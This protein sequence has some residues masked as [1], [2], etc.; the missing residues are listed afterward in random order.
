M[1]E[2]P[3][4]PYRYINIPLVAPCVCDHD[5]TVHFNTWKEYFC[6]MGCGCRQWTPKEAVNVSTD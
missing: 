1:H 3:R 5:K 4:R 2:P 6:T